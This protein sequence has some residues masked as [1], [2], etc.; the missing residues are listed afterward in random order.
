MSITTYFSSAIILALQSEKSADLD[1]GYI[2]LFPVGQNTQS[3]RAR[4][5]F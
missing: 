5:A 2:Q 3:G 1:D 4:Q